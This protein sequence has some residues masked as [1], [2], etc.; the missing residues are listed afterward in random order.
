MNKKNRNSAS[1]QAN[2][3]MNLPLSWLFSIA[4]QLRYGL[5]L[6]VVLTLLLTSGI[7][8]YLSFQA[9]LQQVE[10][11]QQERSHAAAGEINAYLDDLQ[12]K[13][14]YLARVPGLTDLSPEIQD[15]FLE[16]LTR[17]N[18]AYETVAV[19]N[20]KG[21]I[22]SFSSPYGKAIFYQ[23]ETSTSFLQAFR[24][25]EDFVSPVR[26]DPKTRL[27]TVILA[28]PIRNQQDEIN[29]VLMA[30]INLKFLWNVLSQ[31]RVGKTGYAYAI[32]NR[33]YLIAEKGE[34]PEK[35]NL[36]DLS[37]YQFIQKITK[38]NGA[39][40][41]TTYQGLR[42]VEVVGA[43]STIRNGR[44]KVVVELPTLE[45]Y[46]P[47]RKMLLVMGIALSGAILVATELGWFFS[48]QI[49]LPLQR[50][51]KAAAQISGGN[52]D[53]QVTVIQ[54]NELGV[55]ATTFN[56][57]TAQLRGLIKDLRKERNFVSA[58]LDTAG[59]LVVVLDSQGRIIRFNRAC[60]ETTQYSFEEVKD[61]YFWDLFLIP[62]EVEP[63]K[64]LF[65]SL[66]SGELPSTYE[67]YWVTKNGSRRPI[68]WSNTV[69][70]DTDNSVNYII[71]IGIDITERKRVEEALT[72]SEELYRT[73]ARNFPNGA[74]FLLDQDLRYTIAE[75]A[76]LAAIGLSK[77]LLE[78]RMLCE[79]LPCETCELLEPTYRAALAGK[80]TVIEVPYNNSPDSDRSG[81]RIYLL[82]ALP[83]K[84]EGGEIFA[85]MVMTQDITDWKQAEE[86]LRQERDFNTTIVQ[87]SPAFFVAINPDGTVRMMNDA[88]LHA[89]G[90]TFEEVL[91]TDYLSTFIPQSDRAIV[92]EVFER[93]IQLQQLPQQ[94]NYVLTK[95]GEKLLVEWHGRSVAKENGE[96]DFFFGL[97]I[98]I[99]ER[100]RAEEALL[101]SAERDRLSGA[102]ALRIRQSLD[103]Q[104]ILDTTVIEVRNFLL[105]DRVFIS[106]IYSNF[107]VVAESVA[108]PWRPVLGW[109]P[110]D[111][112]HMQQIR[113]MFEN[114]SI[115]VVKDTSQIELS[116]AI[117]QDFSN[118]HIKAY[119]AV[120]ILL[121][122][123][124]WGILM[125]DQCTNPRDWK[126]L[127]ID[128]LSSLS[129][130]VTIAIQQA[131]L[132]QQVQDLNASL[133]RQVET[134]TAQ[135][136]QKM[137]EL[138]ELNELKD[139]FLHAVSHDLR[140]PIMG[141]S[142]VMNNL[143]NKVGDT[144]PISRSI[145]ERMIQSS[146][147]QLGL[148]NSLL[149]AHSSEVRG[150]VLQYEF[151]ELSTLI[152]AI[153]EDLEPLLSKHQASLINRV[154]YDLPGVTAD[155]LQLR[156]VF[157][158]LLTNAL[159]HNPP[160]LRITLE[161]LVEEEMIHC[162]VADNGIG[163]NP[164]ACDRL[165]DR[166]VRGNHARSA[167]IGL[168]LYLCRQ[169]ITA[170]GGQIGAISAP[171]TGATF[172]FTL[173]LATSPEVEK[174]G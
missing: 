3:G 1:H 164:E 112:E 170:H 149:E 70:V 81:S 153:A 44:W 87:T 174:S 123:E 71:S 137:E 17:H 82:H 91:G 111:E 166:Y 145:L 128:L 163:M 162:T 9:Q 35:F 107:E 74:V 83:V 97:G 27:Q 47:V 96:L 50:L 157:E 12:R 66:Q 46:A 6:L 165:F 23:E 105:A 115:H 126:Q 121:N 38:L 159:N 40:R 64:N 18:S 51:T 49:V 20:N 11:A 89:L 85:A 143:L 109:S 132:Y 31:T 140:T 22:V 147:R 130:Q 127:E 52:L 65:K 58:I 55:L 39:R 103:I 88:M 77:E 72:R 60:E 37:G 28:V 142:L 7:L 56:E 84:N 169:I 41:L 148:I 139:E 29:G 110:T 102:M 42:G 135:L 167:G 133:E 33:N 114:K 76:G 122:D 94:N 125:V 160:G 19:F 172:W 78:G 75:G 54:G 62:E 43:I 134:R 171:G 90:Y 67:N 99:T 92:S 151:V 106:R 138:K 16:A 161:A 32:D 10:I 154:P 124:A 104:Q 79:T 63:G 36:K 13:L 158:N 34:S 173:P 131:K 120:P 116:S 118:Y 15:R 141:M 48:R 80:A 108:P 156:R 4:N 21:E 155:P 73:L 68:A 57:M 2:T 95:Q 117:S 5:V 150:V 26:I 30:W 24:Q 101:L 98:D 86:K 152:Q 59:A 14:S 61:K 136:I 100:Q 93:V 8:I 119:L 25:Q 129:T 144:I 168:G 113:A 69:L 45:A 53:T 146:D